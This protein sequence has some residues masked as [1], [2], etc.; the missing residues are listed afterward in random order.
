MRLKIARRDHKTCE[1]QKTG[2]ARNFMGG[3]PPG[4]ELCLFDGKRNVISAGAIVAGN[5]NPSS[6]R[7]VR[8]S[9]R[10]ILAIV[11]MPFCALQLGASGR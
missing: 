10:T 1:S 3:A 11:D 4:L 7:P 9:H 5:T 8:R 2:G 6:V